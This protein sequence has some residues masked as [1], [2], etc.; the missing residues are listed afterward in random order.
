MA[1][2][3]NQLKAMGLTDE[4][5]GAIIE[6]HSDTVTALKGEIETLR[7]QVETLAA[8]TTERDQ[9][10]EQVETLTRNG[11]DAA[12]VQEAFDAYKAQV[13]GEKT[14]TAKRSALDV[15][16]RD[17]VGVKRDAPRTLILDTMNLDDF[18]LDES[19][20]IVDADAHVQTFGKKYADFVSQ[21]TPK[22]TKPIAP[23][24]G[25]GKA[26]TR[27]E[28]MAIPDYQE[29]IRTIAAHQELF[30]DQ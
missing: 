4:Q 10:K 3:R 18:Q 15:L 26:M 12:K 30:N 23:P 7:G 22:G 29:R 1:L 9:L 28:I 16:L 21:V 19:G 27:D 11:G 20:A 24:E 13:E 25:N 8:I 17:K 14:R 2:T 5:V 6:G